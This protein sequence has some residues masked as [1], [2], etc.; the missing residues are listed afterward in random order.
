MHLEGFGR[1]ANLHLRFK[2]GLNLIHGGNEAGKSTL[3]HALL[4]LLYG[5]V[6]EGPDTTL[7]Q[8]LV[9]SLKPWDGKA[10]YA[11][12]LTYA[13]D[14]GQAFR[15]SRRFGPNPDTQ[16]H[17]HP[18]GVDISSQFRGGSQ[19]RLFFAREQLGVSKEVFESVCVVRQGGLTGLET[20]A[21]PITE[22]LMQC[23]AAN[24]DLATSRALGLLETASNE[25][26]GTQHSSSGALAEALAQLSTLEEER[27][28]VLQAQRELYPRLAALNEAAQ[29]LETLELQ[30]EELLLLLARAGRST[31]RAPIV[32]G[33]EIG[34]EVRRNEAE[35]AKWQAW[36]NFP[37]Y[38]RDDVLKL[39]VQRGHLRDECAEAELRAKPAQETLAAL[40]AQEAALKE[41]VTG[42]RSPGAGVGDE[43]PDV[44]VL[45]SEYTTATEAESAASQRY[46]TAQQAF[47]TLEKRLADETKALE[48]VVPLGVSGLATIQ[49]RLQAGRERLAQAKGALTEASS[50][51][52]QV[53]IDEAQ[54]QQ[55]R[56]KGDARA[57]AKPSSEGRP[58]L[59][60]IIGRPKHGRSPSLVD[61][62]PIYQ[63]LVH[64]REEVEA[65][66]QAIR[67][68]EATT[69]WQLGGLLGGTLDDSA[70]TQL[71][72][73]LERH[74]QATSELEQQRIL[75]ASLHSELERARERRTKAHA[76]LQAELN[77]RGFGGTDVRKS[78]A[79]YTKG[80]KRKDQYSRE[81][82]DREI[83]RLRAETDLELLRLRADALQRD[84]RQW[85]EKQGALAAVETQ[86]VAL[87]GRAGIAASA[88]TL[89]STLVTFNEG[90]EN[91]QRWEKAKAALETATRYQRAL[92]DVQTSAIAAGGLRRDRD[93]GAGLAGAQGLSLLG[94][95]GEKTPQEYAAMLQQ[96]EDQRAK[97]HEEYEQ[98]EAT[99]GGASTGY[100]HLAEI[101]EE[102]TAV[103]A[104]I[105]RLESFRAAL[106][107]ARTELE[108]AN[109]EYQKQFGPRL[110]ALLKGGLSR[111]TGERYS[112]VAVDP[113][114][115]AVSVLVPEL[116]TLASVE[117]LSAGTRALVYLLLRISIAHMMGRSKEALPLLLDE[118]LAPL[119]RARQEQ[120]FRLLVELADE[121]QIFFFTKDEQFKTWLEE[122]WRKSTVHQVHVLAGRSMDG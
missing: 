8:G 11:G 107:L 103:K 62:E 86:L 16:I 49:R 80:S 39:V 99:I 36:A 42:L 12:S 92:I 121:T 71:S 110:E 122:K 84:V 23:L 95:Q 90:Y 1:L 17:T 72:E 119:D 56:A 51:W 120:A 77:K 87:L 32:A 63:N 21:A 19:G 43:G 57:A 101:D 82:A 109:Q 5:L 115:L 85:R 48:A 18:E 54:F 118:P 15:V 26:V 68:A 44:P 113:R 53:G 30:R 88:A 25:Q 58:L 111:V 83:V 73:R 13:L 46:Q 76:D 66:Q 52:A 3:Q 60:S 37:A 50:Q 70:F 117:R 38:M 112:T 96:V 45:A 69:F 106:Q 78:L 28:Q 93:A 55:L 40:E 27:R 74:L 81:D 35:V 100:R 7:E 34:A 41:R 10:F 9:A 31:T 116:G 65:A 114:T 33:D 2:P 91:Y 24:M 108:L 89:D 59:S 105:G 67:D 75:V 6:R 47:E 104:R 97:A 79:A 94:L 102:I 64:C 4:A 14:N 29:R 20:C 22:A 61:V 98:L